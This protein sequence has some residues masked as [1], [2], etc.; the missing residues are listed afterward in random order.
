MAKTFDKKKLIRELKKFYPL[1]IMLIPIMAFYIIF[2]YLPMYG[3]LMAFKEFDVFL[4]IIKSP[5]AG[6]NGFYYFKMFLND[7]YFWLVTKNTL[8]I[9]LLKIIFGFPTPLILALL[10]NEMERKTFKKGIQ[11]IL[12]LPRFISW[13][14]ISGIITAMLSPST[15]MFNNVIVNVFHKEPIA[16]MLEKDYIRFIIVV[17]DIWKNAGWGT[18]IY[19]AALA[20]VDPCLHE[21]AIIDGAGRFKRMWY[22]SISSIRSTIVMLFI[23]ALSGILNAGFD[24]IFVLVNPMLYEKADIIDTYVYRMGIV[25]GNYSYATAVGLFKSVIG[26][27]LILGS[28]W[29]FKAFG[30]RGIL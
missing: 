12:Y 14:I 11:T 29:I 22:V 19:M 26:L 5:W 21:A 28:D 30:E 7:D 15:G 16:F 10:L 24:Q 2:C 13:V 18:I 25:L 3:I 4:G 9:S 1:Y 17:S 20:G 8:I 27:I 23:L 6:D